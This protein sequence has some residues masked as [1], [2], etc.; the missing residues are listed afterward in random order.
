MKG[1]GLRIDIDVR[2]VWRCPV[3]G[4]MRRTPG[5]VTTLRCGCKPGGT[6]MQPVESRRRD[7]PV[8]QAVDPYIEIDLDAP[9]EGESAPSV[10]GVGEVADAGGARPAASHSQEEGTHGGAQ[11]QENATGGPQGAPDVTLEDTF[12]SGVLDAPARQSG[13]EVPGPGSAES[14]Q[15]AG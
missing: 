15:R 8:P 5:D 1:P 10:V 12:G 9:V 14:P 6:L 13:T 11:R 7:R 3:C 2:R 4:T